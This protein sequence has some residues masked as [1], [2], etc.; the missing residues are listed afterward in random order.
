MYVLNWNGSKHYLQ[1][2]VS[3]FHVLLTYGATMLV[4]FSFLLTLYSMLVLA[5]LKSIFIMF[6]I[7][8]L[9]NRFQSLHVHHRT[10][11]LIFSPKNYP[12]NSI[13]IFVTSFGFVPHRHQ[14]AGA[15]QDNDN[16]QLLCIVI[17]VIFVILSVSFLMC[18][19]Y[20]YLCI[21][22]DYH[23]LITRNTNS[24]L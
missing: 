5:M 20:I 16:H 22:S 11:L 19:V 8:W 15:C 18:T 3:N 9:P 12:N 17:F 24:N 10:S 1:S 14:L 13:I 7:R 2:W 23:W 4:Q 21:G 6:V